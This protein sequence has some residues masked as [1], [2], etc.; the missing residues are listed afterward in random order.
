MAFQAKADGVVSSDVVGYAGAA[1]RGGGQAAGVGGAFLNVDKSDLTLGDLTVI[2]YDAEEGYADFDVQAKQLDGHGK[3]GT[4]YYWV[5]FTDP[6]EGATYK[7]W[8]GESGEDYNDLVLVPGEGLWVY[9][10]STSFKVQSAGAV[11]QTPIA[12]TLRGGGQA[13]MVSNPMPATLTLGDIAVTGYDADEGYADFDIQ[14]KKLNGYGVGGTTYYWADF[15]EDGVTYFGWYDDDFNDVNDS[16][17]VTAGEGLW[18]YSPSTSF[19]VVFPSPLVN[20]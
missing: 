9:S 8:F 16:V 17:E 20:E 19:S 18:I 10:P 3:G 2:G 11:P 5:D 13:K 7:G 1:L 12:V 14:A 15:E 6:D 4:T